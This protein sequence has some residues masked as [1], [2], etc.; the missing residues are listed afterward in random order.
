MNKKLLAFLISG[1][2]INM[3]MTAAFTAHF[4]IATKNAEFDKDKLIQDETTIEYVDENGGEISVRNANANGAFVKSSDLPDYV[5]N[6]FI[7][8]EDKRFYKHGGL[9]YLRIVKAAAIN[10]KSFS[11][12]EGAST[13]SQ[14]LI[15]NTHLTSEKTLT[16]KLKE[17]KL[18]KQMEKVLSKDEILERYLNTVYFGK[19]CY[20][21]ESASKTYFNKS[22]KDLTL[23]EAAAL[24]A[25]VK[26]P[27]SYSPANDNE[28]CFKRKNLVLSAMNK[29]G[30]ISYGDYSAANGKAVTVSVGGENLNYMSDYLNAV[31]REYELLDA[32]PTYLKKAKVK[33]TTYL[34]KNLQRHI[35]DLTIDGDSDSDKSQIVINN[36]NASV[37]AFYGKNSNLVRCPASTIKPLYVYAP[38]IDNGKIKEST[39]LTDEPTDFGGYSPKN[40]GDKYSGKVTVKTA[41]SKSLNVPAVRLINYFGSGDGVDVLNKGGVQVDGNNLSSALGGGISVSLKKLCDLYSAFPCNGEYVESGFIKKIEVNGK[42]VYERKSE[43]TRLFKSSTAYIISDALKEC[44]K[45]GTAK[46]LRDY[47]FEVCAKTGTNGNKDGN[48]DAYCVAYTTEHTVGVWYGNEDSSLMPQKITGGSYPA[49]RVKSALN[50]I[51]EK[52]LP[53]NFEVPPDIIGVKIDE[54]TLLSEEKTYLCDDKSGKL[55][56]YAAGSEPTDY[57][58]VADKPQIINYNLTVGAN[59]TV[60]TLDAIGTEKVVVYKL[61]NGKKSEVY[62]GG[63]ENVKLSGNFNGVKLEIIPVGYGG[64]FGASVITPTLKYVPLDWWNE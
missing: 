48:I 12:K 40:Y 21:I 3:V 6:A 31:N 10:L 45:T 49:V 60:V 57:A 43:K 1:L 27:K 53:N 2:T 36:K 34:D 11:F 59:E 47:A 52:S 7:A 9:D 37:I 55:Y 22:A 5:K 39:V 8:I 16:R 28:R 54:T 33:V 61:L 24:A 20:G 42:T 41:I 50:K 64:G 62:S 63:I 35:Y 13:I 58:P 46:T 26:S 44:A 23:N 29:Q 18:T 30:L 4:F 14:Q 56:Y 15:K 51:Y 19:G 17:I 32:V 25:T 38:L